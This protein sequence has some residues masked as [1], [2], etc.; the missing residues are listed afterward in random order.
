MAEFDVDAM[1]ERYNERAE[2]VR[3]RPIPP[4]EGD[5]RRGFIKQ[6]ETDLIDFALIANA[7]WEV[8][9]GHLVLRVPLG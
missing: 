7:Q 9:E 4:V 8:T 5:A 3:N 6:A 1:L 2:A